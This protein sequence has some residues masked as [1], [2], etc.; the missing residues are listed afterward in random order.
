MKAGAQSQY[1]WG[2]LLIGWIF[3]MVAELLWAFYSFNG[4]D[5]YPS[6]ADLFFLLGYVPMSI[7]FLIRMWK[8]PRGPD[9]NQILILGSVSMIAG[10]ATFT[11]IFIPILQS[12]DPEFILESVLGLFYPLADLFLLLIVLRIFFT[13]GSG[14]YGMAWR[15]ILIGFITVT[16]SDLFFSYADWNGLYYPDSKATSLS[17]I[18]VDSLYNLSYLLWAFGMYVLHVLLG[19]HEIRR[20]NFQPP[21]VPN[22]YVLIFTDK[23]G[24][25]SGVSQ[26]Y[27]RLF[28]VQDVMRRTLVELLGISKQEEIRIQTQ[29]LRNKKF[30]EAGLRITGISG[31]QYQARIS[32]L[33]VMSSPN[34]YDG[35]ILL[36]RLYTEH[37]EINS[38]LSEYHMSLVSNILSKV[39]N[40]EKMEIG[41]FCYDYYLT[42]I[43]SLYN[44]V[45]QEGGAPMSQSFLDELQMVSN[46]NGWG[47]TFQPQMNWDD[48]PTA[49]LELSNPAWRTLLETAKKFT[50]QLTDTEQV[51]T[52]IKE[53]RAQLNEAV[54]KTAVRLDNTLSVQTQV[55]MDGI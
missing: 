54:L 14:N 27:H 17:T 11:Y 31:M 9:K 37:G 10:F 22:T 4:Q 52:C 36:L 28:P 34:F 8:L 20:I 1:I 43:L 18:G 46:T 15:L 51:N 2:G 53:A 50:S 25:V 49:H 39:D 16:I 23:D 40:S 38:V 3:W 32:G 19:E 55:K 26:N 42:L 47:L 48:N 29:L 33:A 13:F 35:A 24:R 41:R 7:G 45:L 5:P 6:L 44:L 30:H 12:Y 21:L